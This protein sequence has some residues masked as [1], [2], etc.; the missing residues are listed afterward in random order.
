MN[1]NFILFIFV[2]L[3]FI[4]ISNSVFALEEMAFPDVTY[5][6]TDDNEWIE[7]DKYYKEL[8][9]KKKEQEKNKPIFKQYIPMNSNLEKDVCL[10]EGFSTY[11]ANKFHG[12]KT[13][14]GEVYNKNFMTAAMNGI[15][16][17]TKVK[18]TN[19]TNNKSIIVKVNDR[20]GSKKNVI[21]LSPAAF[22]KIANL[23]AGRVKVNIEILD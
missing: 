16:F 11:Y 2:I 3:G 1:K 21:D 6:I 17:G 12:R 19:L 23:S 14:S 7:K 10:V 13:A 9:E 20:I 5:I 15:K 18:V 8:E 4:C 22:K